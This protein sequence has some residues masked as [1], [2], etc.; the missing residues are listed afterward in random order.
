MASVPGNRGALPYLT[1]TTE[2]DIKAGT[3]KISSFHKRSEKQ[4]LWGR[5]KERGNL[6]G[7]HYMV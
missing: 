1:G 4:E 3:T 2:V 7:H 5:G 6:S